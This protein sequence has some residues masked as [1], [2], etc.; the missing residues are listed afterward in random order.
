MRSNIAVR[1][2]R[3]PFCKSCPRIPPAHTSSL[4][5]I[6][7]GYEMETIRVLDH[8]VEQ[9]ARQQIPAVEQV[10]FRC[11]ACLDQP[12]PW[13]KC[14]RDQSTF[15]GLLPP[16]GG[17]RIPPA[18]GSSY[19]RSCTPN[20]KRGQVWSFQRLRNTILRYRDKTGHARRFLV[21]SPGNNVV[22]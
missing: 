12:S 1:L 21:Q 8:W 10:A 13:Y 15:V 20:T 4:S 16:P 22:D 2:G 9:P 17:N 11:N 14:C 3:L 6:R 18:Y 5:L 7:Y 19:S